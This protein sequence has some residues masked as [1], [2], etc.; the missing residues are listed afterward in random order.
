[1]E[2]EPGGQGLHVLT[3]FEP[4]AVESRP[5]GHAVGVIMPK[6]GQYVPAGQGWQALLVD[7]RSIDEYVPG[8]HA[9]GRK[10]AV[11]Q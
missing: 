6:F 9:A 10:L 4:I 1:M 3:V 8:T 7:W 11:W 2:N 5:A